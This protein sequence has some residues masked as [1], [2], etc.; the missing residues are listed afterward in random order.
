M[1]TKFENLNLSDNMLMVSEHTRRKNC[2]EF[3]DQILAF[4]KWLLWQ[5]F[6]NY[7]FCAL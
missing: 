2:M 7:F 5:Q 3:E 4:C 1:R 6:Y